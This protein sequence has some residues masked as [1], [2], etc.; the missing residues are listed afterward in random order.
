M[1]KYSQN[2]KLDKWKKLVAL[3]EM[4]PF[5]VAGLLSFAE[6]VISTLIAGSPSLNRIQADILRFLFTGN[7][8]RM[9]QA[10]RGQAKTTITAIYAVFMLIHNPHYRIVIF[11]QNSRRAKEIAGWVIKIMNGLDFLEFMRPDKFSGDKSS[12]TEGYEIHHILKGSGASPSVAAYSIEA[13]AQGARADII[14]ADDVESLQN[15]RT[16]AGRDML[17]EATKEFESINQTGDIIYL[18]TPQSVN[19]IY[20]N[21]PSRGYEVRIWTGRYPT[22][23]QVANY[24]EFLA[25]I[26]LSDIKND[27][28]LQH[29]GGLD[30]KQGKPTCP[31][32]YDDAKLIEK[33]ISQGTA[34]FQLQFMLNTRLSDVDRYPLRL[35]DIIFANFSMDEAPI[36]PMWSNNVTEIIQ[37]APRF[38]NK[39]TD[40]LYRMI[41]K[42]YKWQAFDRKICF[43][44]PAGGGKNGDQTGVAI[45][46]VIGTTIYVIDVFGFR[47]GYEEETLKS[48]VNRVKASGCRQVYIEKNMGYG[49]FTAVIKPYFES[50]WKVDVTD[51]DQ[52]VTGQKEVR[53]I[54]TLEPFFKTHRIVFNETLIQQDWDSIQN[55]PTELKMA[56]S[57][58]GQISNIT[59]DRN[60][61]RH[62][63]KVDALYGAVAQIARELDYDEIAHRARLEHEEMIAYMEAWNDPRKRR[64]WLSGSIS[65]HDM[66]RTESMNVSDSHFRF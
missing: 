24:G 14:I 36:A 11:S 21:L 8:Y 27:P 63:D 2:D 39:P 53:V 16:Q 52:Y 30:G 35:S 12:I 25:P 20:N 57:L 60:S 59:L 33:E 65:M 29:G 4:F 22:N 54:E 42:E 48:I 64:E 9:V 15:S 58:F 13:G 19:S 10:Q 17:E 46:G 43:I 23:E 37:T 55:Y 44:D 3:Q 7:L 62:D 66:Q 41:S 61:L 18:G 38:G 56:Y 47:G 31:E 34:K 50:M 6:V 26:I 51:E 49:A 1:A 32:M 45:I 5:S 28:S 40:K